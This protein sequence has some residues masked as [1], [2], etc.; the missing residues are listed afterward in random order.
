MGAICDVSPEGGGV[1][2]GST[3]R[4][5]GGRATEHIGYSAASLSMSS[6]TIAW[7]GFCRIALSSVE[8]SVTPGRVV[9]HC[10]PSRRKSPAKKSRLFA[11]ETRELP[12]SSRRGLFFSAGGPT[13]V[14]RFGDGDRVLGRGHSVR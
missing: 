13:R 7:V 6:S 9:G 12:A 8:Q 3:G 1:M 11:R 14:C 2:G 5:D 4:Q 10:H